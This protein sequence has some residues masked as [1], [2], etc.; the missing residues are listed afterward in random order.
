MNQSGTPFT[1]SSTRLATNLSPPTG[2]RGVAS[3]WRPDARQ[4]DRDSIPHDVTVGS[5]ARHHADALQYREQEARQHFG[6][7]AF[8]QLAGGLRLDQTIG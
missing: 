5:D 7:Y 6:L 4:R 3:L 8:S 2:V 1:A